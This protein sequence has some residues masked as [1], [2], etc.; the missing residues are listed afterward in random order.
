[1]VIYKGSTADLKS[2]IKDHETGQVQSTRDFRPVKFIGYEAYVLKSDA[3][4]REK[5]LK[6]NEGRRLLKQ[7][8]RDIINAK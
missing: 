2:R 1:M 4:R 7:Q 5:F 6:T 3:Q 8:Y